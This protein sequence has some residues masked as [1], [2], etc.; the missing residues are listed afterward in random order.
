MISQKKHTVFWFRRDLRL[1][2]NCG[3]F[4]A[5]KSGNKVLPL[6][7]Y[8]K[9]VPTNT[10]Q[11]ALVFERLATL[12]K[13]L[14]KYGSNLGIYSGEPKEVFSLI[15]KTFSIE[16]IFANSEYEPYSVERDKILFLFFK[17][18][19]VDFL[20]FKDSV[21][22]EKKEIEKADGTPYLI[23]TP[24]SKKWLERFQFNSVEQFP[25][26]NFKKNFC[27][28][29]KLPSL[30]LNQIGFEKVSISL[31][32]YKLTSKMIQNYE[33]LRDFPLEKNI[34]F[35][36]EL[37]WREFFMQLLWCFPHLK[38]KSFR[39]KY[40]N[41]EWNDD[42]KLF[43]KWCDGKTGFP[44]IDAGMKELKATGLMHNRVR[45]L[46]GSFLCKNLLIDWR[47]GERFFAE[48]LLDYEMSSNV[49]NWQWVAS[50]GTDAAPYFRIFNPT[51]QMLKFDRNFE[52]I[53]KWIF[54]F[55]KNNYLAP[56]INYEKSR[57]DCL[58]VYKSLK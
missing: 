41:T 33:A 52:Y 47:L 5:L 24:F 23:Y 25:S 9:N 34:T 50:C 11:I 49:G 8:D 43:Q 15:F 35:L 4:H 30:T 32:A 17:K 42:K 13:E 27:S 36:K 10:K 3:L 1:E 12:H 28:Q 38:N 7:I 57:K 40:D 19:N 14:K 20:L 18:Q 29:T 53:K 31:P 6:F 45:M 46:V 37:I 22:F 21:I 55:E 2:D 56:I 54:N 16:K 39:T 48:N 58:N 44:I 26:E 51:T